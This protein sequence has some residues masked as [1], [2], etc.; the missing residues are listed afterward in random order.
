M[1]RFN[2]PTYVHVWFR[3]GVTLSR[4][5]NP[6]TNYVDLIKEQI[7]G[8]VA[9]LK[10]GESVIPQKF[11]LFLSGIDYMDIWLFATV[12]DGEMPAE[13]N[14]RSIIISPRERAVT[15]ESRIEVVIDG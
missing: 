8:K 7:L 5:M 2:R 1:I 4:N 14:Q 13:F 15:D 6:P 10:A 11:H 12:E 3:V 9:E